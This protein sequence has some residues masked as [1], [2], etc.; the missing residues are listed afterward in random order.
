MVRTH[1]GTRNQE[2]ACQQ[3]VIS[4]GVWA[5]HVPLQGA[6]PAR[7]PGARPGAQ[8]TLG[9]AALDIEK[10]SH[11]ASSGSFTYAP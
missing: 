1:F 3:S 4:P 6:A 11:N 10:W 9:G 8:Q 2:Y 7:C 5:A